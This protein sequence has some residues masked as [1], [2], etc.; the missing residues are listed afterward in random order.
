MV[1]GLLRGIERATFVAL[2]ASFTLS[3]CRERTSD[4]PYAKQAFR[5]AYAAVFAIVLLAIVTPVASASEAAGVRTKNRP[6]IVVE[7]DIPSLPLPDAISRLM[8]QMLH[9]RAFEPVKSDNPIASRIRTNPVKGGRTANE[10][11]REMLRGTGVTYKLSPSNFLT[12]TLPKRLPEPPPSQ[13]RHDMA[14][15]RIISSIA[16]EAVMDSPSLNNRP[17][18]RPDGVTARTVFEGPELRANSYRTVGE[19][20]R[21]MLPSHV[22]EAVATGPGVIAGDG[23]Q[24][25]VLG[26]GTS[27]TVVL[28][29]GQPRAEVSAGGVQQQSALDRLML[30]SVERIEVLTGTGSSFEGGGALAS[31]VNI[32][33]KRSDSGTNVAVQGDHYA[34]MPIGAFFVEGE[35]VVPLAEHSWL[36]FGGGLTLEENVLLK[37]RNFLTSGRARAA[38][39]NPSLLAN[40][41]PPLGAGVN[42]RTLDGSPLL[43]G[44]T[45]SFLNVPDGW[46]G[47]PALLRSR[48]GQYDYN[49]AESAQDIGGGRATAQAHRRHEHASIAGKFQLTGKLLADI[50]LGFSRE[51]R[52]GNVS[53]ADEA[54]GRTYLLPAAANPFNKDILVTK[55]DAIGDGVMTNKQQSEYAASGFSY[56]LGNGRAARA[57]H[58]FSRA[59][60]QSTLPILRPTSDTPN[61]GGGLLDQPTLLYALDRIDTPR[62][63]NRIHDTVLTFSSP[64]F[65]RNEAGRADPALSLSA[66]RRHQE[67]DNA[68]SLIP[69]ILNATGVEAA[70]TST[71]SQKVYSLLGA[72][73][74]P[75]YLSESRDPTLEAELSVRSDFYGVSLPGAARRT[76]NFDSFN[77]T[78]SLGWR[79]SRWLLLRAGYGTGFL[80]PALALLTSP[81]DQHA[82][83]LPVFDSLRNGEP[84]GP[85]TIVTGG[86]LDLRPEKARTYRAG[87]VVKAPSDSWRVSVD[88][89]RI[90]KRDVVLGPDEL[91]YGNP[92]TFLELFPERVRREGTSDGSPGRIT[93]IDSSALNVARQ[94]LRAFEI[95]SSWKR[96]FLS[97]RTLAIH[98]Y[99]TY[100]PSFERQM[101]AGAPEVEH[102][103][104]GLGP[105]RFRGSTSAVYGN[106]TWQVGLTSRFTSRYRVSRE[107]AILTSQG[108][109]PKVS[110]QAYH[111]LFVSYEMPAYFNPEARMT[112]RLDMRNVFQQDA[113]F[114]AS[115]VYYESRYG[116]DELPLYRLSFGMRF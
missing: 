61:A 7:I 84:L 94:D 52:R 47:D 100:V 44:G 28:I 85:L 93:W 17:L 25:N 10:A 99:G 51:T 62:A 79:P 68:G 82:L 107:A 86:S 78:I 31:V 6:E 75:L 65:R 2:A 49:L 20:L 32:I 15:V 22:K 116:A 46:N 102:A 50:D 88:Y 92:N 103:G 69:G 59:S 41:S 89:T 63:V 90:F 38:E 19:F 39:N 30:S 95:S 97:Q 96:D 23:R 45:A 58:T 12:L 67:L 54:V 71:R 77:E 87:F 64:V 21:A 104:V 115:E 91:F 56:I 112:F 111:D 101:I 113:P 55:G 11:L 66:Q 13:E 9:L 98:A 34:E 73:N 35:H 74:L 24:L 53:A 4:I 81:V 33:R 72:F 16:P 37:D 114:D 40:G 80:P 14:E 70:S 5:R 48:Q 76:A 43:P 36:S 27:H 105:P 42:V 57:L 18:Y 83:Q 109:D 60:A 3:R 106:G 26:M 108:D 110:S 1:A 8:D 29:D